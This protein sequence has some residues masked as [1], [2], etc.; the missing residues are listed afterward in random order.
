VR[1]GM[2]YDQ[3]VRAVGFANRGTA[4]RV[5]TKALA[6]RLADG[7]DDL[8]HIE[9][10]RLDVLQAALWPRM[11]KGEVRAINRILR[12]IDRRCRLLGLYAETTVETPPW[13][14]VVPEAEGNAGPATGAELH[15]TGADGVEGSAV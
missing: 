12:I 2:S 7:I 10:A 13:G 9:L 15:D 11:Q 4:H 5:V 1:R 8:G 3:A 14:L 6:A